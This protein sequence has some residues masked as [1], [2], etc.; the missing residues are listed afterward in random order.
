MQ[1]CSTGCR[2][3]LFTPALFIL[4]QVTLVLHYHHAGSFY[5][6]HDYLHSVSVSVD[7]HFSTPNDFIEPAELQLFHSLPVTGTNYSFSH[8]SEVLTLISPSHSRAP[9]VTFVWQLERVV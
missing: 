3:L 4:L 5:D 1:R 2:L 8:C 6:E 9:P 7:K